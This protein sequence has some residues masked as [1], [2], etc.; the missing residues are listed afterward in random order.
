MPRS[1]RP[2][3]PASAWPATVAAVTDEV[4]NYAAG[5][6]PAMS[7]NIQDAVQAALEAFLRRVGRA[8]EV[9]AAMAP[10][11]RARRRLRAWVGG[12]PAAGARSIPS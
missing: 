9:R 1:W 12:R 3:G 7:A 4:P 10:R 6:G 2:C 11:R 8:G 5:L